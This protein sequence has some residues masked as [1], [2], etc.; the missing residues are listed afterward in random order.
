MAIAVAGDLSSW[1]FSGYEPYY[2][3]YD[4]FIG[5]PNCIH[6][7]VFKLDDPPDVQ[8]AQVLFWLNFLKA[9]IAPMEPIGKVPLDVYKLLMCKNDT[10]E[11]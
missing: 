8:L 2:L 5:D 10:T 1:E 3:I 6:M 9:R 4:H 11:V 7:I